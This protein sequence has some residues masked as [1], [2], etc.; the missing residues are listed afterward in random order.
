MSLTAAVLNPIIGDLQQRFPELQIRV[1]S[2]FEPLELD[3]E[4]FDLGLQYG[5]NR[6]SSFDV[7]PIADEQVYPVCSPE[8]LEHLPEHPT[9]EDLLGQQLLHVDY[10]EPAWIGWAEFLAELGRTSTD[11]LAGP[12]F[13]TYVVVLDLAERGE[14]IALGWGHTAKP[15][16]E[17]GRLVRIPGLTIDIADALLAYRPVGHQPWAPVD[18][19]LEILRRSLTRP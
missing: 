3:E 19:L 13:S 14:G 4:P 1:V 9:I 2:S 16:I 6:V 17:A 7:E 15:R 8:L 5:R 18:D 12:V 10:G 11:P